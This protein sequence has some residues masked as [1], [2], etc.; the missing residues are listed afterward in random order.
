MEYKYTYPG[1][2]SF[3]PYNAMNT[4]HIL[5]PVIE[6]KIYNNNLYIGGSLTKYKT[7]TYSN[8]TL[9]VRDKKYF[10]AVAT[11]VSSPP[12]TFTSTGE[13]TTFYPKANI[14]YE[15]QTA[16]GKPQSITYN[17]AERVVYLWGYNYQHP[18]AEI[19]NAT[20]AD[21]TAKI[22]AGTLN[23]I[24]A[25]TTPTASDFTAI[26]NLRTQLPDAHVTTYTYTPLF[27]ISSVTD[28]GSK[29][30]TYEYDAFGRLMRIKDLNGK[31][32]EENEYHYRN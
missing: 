23:S 18:I 20:Y 22:S 8:K 3:A 9:Y 10:S 5:S 29:T 2:Y 21:V 12:A 32:L 27:G 7:H 6:E 30:V 4:A 26:N 14:K 16:Y 15:N 28:P 17:D 24:A 31:T 19:K 1:D 11:P 13:N 25:R